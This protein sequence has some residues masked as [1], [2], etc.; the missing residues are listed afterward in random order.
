MK[1][2]LF[3]RWPEGYR[4][5]VRLHPED[6]GADRQ[7]RRGDGNELNIVYDVKVPLSDGVRL[8]GNLYLPN[9]P[10]PHPAI[11]SYIPYLKDG[12]GGLGLMDT[13][14][15]H[16]ASRGYAVVQ[17]D[18]RGVGSSEGVN[19]Y[20]F[21]PRERH[22]SHEAVEW[23]ASQ[24]WC[25][26]SVGMWGISYGGITAI[27][28]ASTNPPHLKAIV[29]VHATDDNWD[30]LFVHR[31]SRLMLYPDAHWGPRMAASNLLPPLR[32]DG[33][34]DWLRRWQERLE[35]NSPWHLTWHGEPPT[36]DYWELQKVDPSLVEAP[37]FAICGWHDAYPEDIFRIFNAVRGPKK[38]LFGP[39]KHTCPDQAPVQAIDFLREA[40]RWWDRWLKGIRNG[41]ESEPPVTIYVQGSRGY[42]RNESEWPIARRKERRLFAV[43]TGVLRYDVPG[44]KLEADQYEYDARC[45]LASI[46]Y[47]SVL[48]PITYPA[49]QTS[50]DLL[51]LR[52]TSEPLKDAVEVT[53][54]PVVRLYFSTEAPIEEINLVTKLLDVTPEGNSYLVSHENVGGARATSAGH[55]GGSPLYM[56]TIALRPTSYQYGKGHRIRLC[57]SGSDFPFIWPTPRRYVLRLYTGQPYA[58]ELLL[59][60]VP[61]R[62]QPLP[63][64][65][66]R[67]LTRLPEKGKAILERGASYSVTRQL[68][69][70]VASFHG[71]RWNRIEVEPNTIC[72]GDQEF[73]LSV[74]SD[75][76]ERAN[77]WETAVMK[78]ER[79]TSAVEVR[80]RT[81]VTLRAIS[82][83]AEVKQDGRL[84]WQR[85]WEKHW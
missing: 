7:V 17:L 81:V 14:Q 28:A 26:G 24:P 38:V 58:T 44:E 57:V 65:N 4:K 16:F 18:F 48:Q 10:G 21:D 20:P 51:S 59:P 67:V 79:P 78:L 56:A 23:I 11:L 12:F 77:T 45:G 75:H 33:T 73:D 68:V 53:G 6:T 83:H 69:T 8:A 36:P 35:G 43:S 15:R 72:S 46:A 32:A 42:W 25:T 63:T 47:D 1:F 66:L 39:W 50:D 31:G 62:D 54:Q 49:D 41:V 30:T 34:P 19:P 60:V 64:P 55:V 29:P 2:I 74:D 40:D 70:P 5:S 61:P 3:P 80:V 84:F 9:E 27:A 71:R 22:D 85:E 82:M 76:P 37:I 52:Y 13:Y